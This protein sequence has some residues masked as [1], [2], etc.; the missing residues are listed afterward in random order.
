MV[1]RDEDWVDG[2]IDRDTNS[3]VV[4]TGGRIVFIPELVKL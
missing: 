4:I 2:D 3:V 1:K